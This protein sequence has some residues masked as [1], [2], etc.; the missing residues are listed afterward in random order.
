MIGIMPRT[1]LLNVLNTDPN[2]HKTSN[3]VVRF[4]HDRNNTLSKSKIDGEYNF[5][6]F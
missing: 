3:R 1:F 2:V 4:G 6:L 5:K